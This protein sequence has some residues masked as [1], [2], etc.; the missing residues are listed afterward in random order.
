MALSNAV[1]GA[2]KFP[3]LITWTDTEGEPVDLSEATITGRIWSAVVAP[4]NIEGPLQLDG[5]GSEGQFTWTYHANDVAIAG[6]FRVQFTA[7][8]AG[9]LKARTLQE[10]WEVKPA[11]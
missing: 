2:T 9:N 5:D 1:Q 8:Y 7:T 3:Q 11:I 4:R 6:T 10:K